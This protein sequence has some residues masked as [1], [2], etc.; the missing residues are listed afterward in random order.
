MSEEGEEY[1]PYDAEVRIYT[2]PMWGHPVS[3]FELLAERWSVNAGRMYSTGQEAQ[4][5]ITKYANE[6]REAGNHPFW[7]DPANPPAAVE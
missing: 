7:E 6:L 5:E 3:W 1:G 4:D 2:H